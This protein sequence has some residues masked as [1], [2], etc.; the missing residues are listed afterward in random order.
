MK[1]TFKK[2]TALT[3][4][5]LTVASL[6]SCNKDKPED[7][8]DSQ[9]SNSSAENS[10]TAE[11]KTL[12]LA[13]LSGDSSLNDSIR[14]FNNSNDD[15]EI[16]LIN[17]GMKVSK[18]E[19]SYYDDALTMLKMDLVSGNT[20]DI[21][22]L[23]SDSMY[24][25]V[26]GG[27]LA[28]LYPLMESGGDISK[29]DFLPNVLEGLE[30]KDKLPVICSDFYIMTAV[31]KT[32]NVGAD[33]ENWSLNEV[34]EFYNNLPSDTDLLYKIWE[35][36]SLMSG[37]TLETFIMRKIVRD[38]VDYENAECSFGSTFIDAVN[39]LQGKDFL[40]SNLVQDP[41]KDISAQAWSLI[42]DKAFVNCTHI[43]GMDA[44][45][46][47]ET[48]SVFGGE[49]ITFV[50]Y[51]SESGCGAIVRTG[52]MYGILGDSDSKQEAWEFIASQLKSSE[53]IPVL[54]ER[55]EKQAASQ[56][57]DSFALRKPQQ[58]PYPEN[59][60]EITISD[61]TVQKTVDY[62]MSV[63]FDPYYD[64]Q[65]ENIIREEYTSVLS[66]EKTIDECI[67]IL[68]SRISIYLSERS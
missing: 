35:W 58:L 64:T 1:N 54:T 20:P 45:L 43:S 16:E 46:S 60:T 50:G 66:G 42:N 56:K 57:T 52:T 7:I 36:E 22:S 67:E 12:T 61:E 21:V 53:N 29:D 3:L 26:N 28:D 32:S 18:S 19:D 27:Y 34:V 2:I 6:A 37:N 8:S 15:F 9:E 11:K 13:V 48:S 30:Y 4:S 14:W 33:S 40:K 63:E 62:I 47:Q 39:F 5:I 10:E 59:N 24:V 41:E 49:D 65:V 23:P 38:C 17:Y 44:Y 68:E 31:A 51:P 25:L 55:L